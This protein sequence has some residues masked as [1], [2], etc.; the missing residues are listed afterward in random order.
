MAEAI[1]VTL[2]PP[3]TEWCRDCGDEFHYLRGAVRSKCQS[4]GGSN[5][6]RGV[7][8]KHRGLLSAFESRGRYNLLSDE[9]Q[10]QYIFHG[11]PKELLGSTSVGFVVG[12]EELDTS[13]VQ[14][15]AIDLKDIYENYLYSKDKGRIDKLVEFLTDDY[16]DELQRKQAENRKIEIESELYWILKE[17]F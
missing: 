12:T 7:K 10:S 3:T 4:C 11:L 17:G 1:K 8:L 2:N 14:S 15:L 13:C 5:M 16:M 6:S 9:V